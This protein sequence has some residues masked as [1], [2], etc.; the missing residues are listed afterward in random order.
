MSVEALPS[1]VHVVVEVEPSSL[2]ATQVAVSVRAPG[3]ACVDA[4]F[5]LED[6]R[7]ICRRLGLTA[8]VEYSVTAHAVAVSAVSDRLTWGHRSE[9]RTFVPGT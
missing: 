6:G 1:G 5:P 4:D 9:S 7:A 3:Q 2:S 8:G